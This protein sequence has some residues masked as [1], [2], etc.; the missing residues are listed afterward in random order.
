M[1]RKEEASCSG[2]LRADC[3]VHRPHQM[4]PAETMACALAP[5]RAHHNHKIILNSQGVVQGTLAP[6]KRAVKDQDYREFAYKNATRKK[7]TVKWTRS[8]GPVS[9]AT[10]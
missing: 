10:V 2:V 4:Y 6:W 8:N 7:L 9:Q 1:G 3:N 5:K